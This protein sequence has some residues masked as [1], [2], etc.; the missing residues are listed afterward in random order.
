M[1][2]LDSSDEYDEYE[3]YDFDDEYNYSESLIEPEIEKIEDKES[4]NITLGI[5]PWSHELVWVGF[6]YKMDSASE[7]GD[8]FEINGEANTSYE[9]KVATPGNT[10][11]IDEF[12]EIVQKSIEDSSKQMYYE[13]YCTEEENFA[14]YKDA[15]ECK[16]AVD[17][18]FG[19]NASS[20]DLD[21]L[22]DEFRYM[23]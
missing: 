23:I 13:T 14:G 7:Y 9:S 16:A 8:H 11:S 1:G 17:E 22:L 21:D 2:G 10:K 19:E 5:K 20:G 18:A 12:V 6:D 15:A 3:E 4:Y